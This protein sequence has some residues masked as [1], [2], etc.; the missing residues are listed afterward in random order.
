[1]SF[2]KKLFGG[3]SSSESA[4]AGD[5]VLGEEGYKDF[6]IKAIEMR[7]GS[8]LQLAGIIEKSVGGELKTY[9]FVRADRMSSKD[10]LVALAFNKGRQIIDEQGERI[11]S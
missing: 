1:M 10:D 11:F 4:P 7:A 8:E 6:L 3:G 9:R 2:L 5:K